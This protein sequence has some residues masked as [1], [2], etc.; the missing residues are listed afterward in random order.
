MISVDELV[1]IPRSKDVDSGTDALPS[2]TPAELGNWLGSVTVM[3]KRMTNSQLR[4][5]LER[6]RMNRQNDLGG[7]Q[8]VDGQENRRRFSLVRLRKTLFRH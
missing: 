3:E 4:S 7:P 1:S 8:N 5:I 6:G 2:I